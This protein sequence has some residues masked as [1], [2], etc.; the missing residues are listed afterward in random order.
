MATAV[1][2]VASNLSNFFGFIAETSITYKKN[3]RICI[4]GGA[5]G[6]GLTAVDF[7]GT[8]TA[9]NTF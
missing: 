3:A 5:A 2:A 7:F 8:I 9:Y 4:G 6:F 1:H